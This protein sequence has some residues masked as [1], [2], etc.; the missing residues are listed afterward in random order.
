MK[1]LPF[2]IVSWAASA[3][4][5]APLFGWERH[6]H[7][8]AAVNVYAWFC[9]VMFVLGVLCTFSKTSRAAAITTWRNRWMVDKAIGSISSLAFM[10]GVVYVGWLGMFG[11]L[12][13]CWLLNMA[14]LNSD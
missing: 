8:L 1:R 14:V 7:A 5:F 11:T 2:W 10:G 4:L 13:V 9:C 12:L 3:V 6:E